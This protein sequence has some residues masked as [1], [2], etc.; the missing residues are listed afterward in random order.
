MKVSVVT[1]C[2]NSE[3]TI[4]DTIR[5]VVAQRGVDIE[6]I[7]IDGVS[8]D[9]TLQILD[10]YRDHVD[11]LV[12][13]PDKGLYDAMNKGLARATGDVVGFL[14]SDDMFADPDALATLISAMQRD[15]SDCVFADVDLIDENDQIARVYSAANFH[16][17]KFERAYAVPHPSFYARTEM[18][19]EA[20][21]FRPSFKIA[22]D[23]ELMIKLMRVRGV[24][25]TYVRRTVVRMRLGGVSTRGLKSYRISS[26]ELIQAIEDNGLKA[27]RLAVHGRIF[28]KGLET[29]HGK[30]R[31]I[32]GRQT[33]AVANQP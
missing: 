31:R 2:L 5:S 8:K 33:P 29:L 27:N 16:P 23:F 30:F 22:S 24:R 10:R 28:R 17:S 6:Y 7:V 15:G 14:N 26:G 9:S 32:V 25:W 11:V 4:E 20:G 13:E 21:G 12:S 3:A 19:R 18:V 1:V